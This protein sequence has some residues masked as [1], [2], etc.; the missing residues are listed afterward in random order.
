VYQGEANPCAQLT[1]Q[2]VI[3]IRER[4]HGGQAS[5]KQ[6]AAKHGISGALVSLIVA[7]KVWAHA[8][9]PVTPS[10]RYTYRVRKPRETQVS[11]QAA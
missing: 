1:E 3:D 4:Y 6:L 5:G 11:E 8:P 7:G 9:G 2:Q 10:R